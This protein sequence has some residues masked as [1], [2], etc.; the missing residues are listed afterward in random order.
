MKSLHG[1]S[2]HE[3]DQS[4]ISRYVRRNGNHDG[5]LRQHRRKHSGSR[6]HSEV[7]MISIARF[8]WDSTSIGRY[9]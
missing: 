1:K 5:L 9:Y 2:L 7:H 8:F 3:P 4:I 6:E